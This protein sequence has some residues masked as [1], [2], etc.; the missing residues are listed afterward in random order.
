MTTETRTYR[1]DTGGHYFDGFAGFRVGQ[2]YRLSYTREGDDVLL[3]LPHAPG[4]SVRL[5]YDVFVRAWVS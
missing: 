1:G 5:P 3:Q 4:K 2:T